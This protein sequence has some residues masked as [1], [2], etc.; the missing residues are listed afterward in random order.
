MTKA[1]DELQKAAVRYSLGEISD[2]Q[3]QA[4][5]LE[6]YKAQMEMSKLVEHWPAYQRRE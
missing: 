5:L 2:E 1:R 6:H 3:F 4:F